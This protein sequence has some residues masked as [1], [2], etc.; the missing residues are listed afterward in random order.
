MQRK[1][2]RYLQAKKCTPS[3]SIFSIEITTFTPSH[4]QHLSLNSIRSPIFWGLQEYVFSNNINPFLWDSST[5]GYYTRFLS[6]HKKLSTSTSIN[7][8][9]FASQHLLVQSQN[10][11]HQKDMW[12]VFRA[13]TIDTKR[14]QWHRSSVFVV[15]FEKVL[16]IVQVFSLLALN[17]YILI[18]LAL[19]KNIF[20]IRGMKHGISVIVKVAYLS[21]LEFKSRSLLIMWQW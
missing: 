19:L 4:L 14:R 12:N 13:D 20:W 10:L 8:S 18:E 7:K 2:V 21:V 15:E 1:E 17:K 5:D 6:I 3:P 9:A 11:K 16:P